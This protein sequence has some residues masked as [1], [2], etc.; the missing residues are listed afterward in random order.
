MTVELLRGTLAWSAVLNMGILL[1]WF[2]F[3]ALASDWVYRMHSKFYKISREH[4]DTIFE[5]N[6][7]GRLWLSETTAGMGL[8]VVPSQANFILVEFPNPKRS[9]A[10]RTGI[11]ASE[12]SPCDDLGAPIKIISASPSDGA[13]NWKKSRK[14]SEA[15]SRASSRNLMH[16]CFDQCIEAVPKKLRARV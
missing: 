15:S 6:R 9:A 1:W 3:I 13:R 5:A 10:K 16:F 4:F 12:A 8:N 7:S 14:P 11:Y 2:L